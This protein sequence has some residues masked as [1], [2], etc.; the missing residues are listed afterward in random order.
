MSQVPGAG[1]ITIDWRGRRA[2]TECRRAWRRHPPPRARA[3]S[4]VPRLLPGRYLVVALED[5]GNSYP[6]PDPPS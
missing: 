1:A 3:S 2:T 5:T 4:R 6:S